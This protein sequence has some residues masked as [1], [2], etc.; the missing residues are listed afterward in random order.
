ML[1]KKAE[2]KARKAEEKKKRDEQKSKQRTLQTQKRSNSNIKPNP[3]KR[4]RID[5]VKHSESDTILKSNESKRARQR[6]VRTGEHSAGSAI[7]MNM[8]Y[9]CFGMYE[10][11]AR[12]GTE[13]EWRGCVCGHWVHEDSR[14]VLEWRYGGGDKQGPIIGQLRYPNVILGFQLHFMCKHVAILKQSE[15]H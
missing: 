13:R 5:E 7:D 15:M 11:D 8:C 2:E 10:E 14:T 4:M 1:K 9:I 6:E 12:K 3:P